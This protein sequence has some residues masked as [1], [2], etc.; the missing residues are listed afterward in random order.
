MKS[1][2]VFGLSNREKL[3][4]EYLMTHRND[5]VRHVDILTLYIDSFRKIFIKNLSSLNGELTKYIQTTESAVKNRKSYLNG[6]MYA[7]KEGFKQAANNIL[8]VKEEFIILTEISL[9]AF[10]RHYDE[11]FSQVNKTLLKTAGDVRP[12]GRAF[13]NPYIVSTWDKEHQPRY[14]AFRDPANME[15]RYTVEVGF[16]DD[17]GFAELSIINN[18]KLGE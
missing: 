11:E 18:Y 6:Y 10:D 3:A 13:G 4:R 16:N 1:A 2:E 14:S 12:L 7:I 17:M 8:V 9:E 15:N 5:I